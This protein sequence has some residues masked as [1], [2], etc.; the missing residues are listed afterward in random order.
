M[1]SRSELREFL[2]SRRARITPQQA[3]LP[4]YGG[5]RRVPGLRRDELANL[6]GVSVEYYTKLERGNAQGVSDSVLEALARALRLDDAERA[7]LFDLARTSSTMA[8][9]R[10]RPSRER[11]RPGIQQLLDSMTEVPAIVQN[12]RLDLLA[13]NK[14]SRALFADMLDESQ[15]GTGA[16]PNFAR[17]TFLDPRAL[18]RYPDWRHTAGD[19][20][21][22]LRAEAGR[23]PDDRQ[24]NE[25]V[26]EL[27]TRST[28]FG[29]MWASHN[30][31]WHTTGTKKLHHPVA[32]D[33][34][35]AYEGLELAADP[36]QTLIAFTAEPGSPSQQ[37]LTFLASWSASAERASDDQAAREEPAAGNA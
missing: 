27:T 20:V 21:A 24:L 32:G 7:H 23:S 9:A 4:Q 31:R 8:R 15:P 26:G 2:T 33:L 35:L 1:D 10:R 3:G 17:Y 19:I 30:V 12:G 22:L 25:L 36:D 16:A 14:L 5:R 28:E 6:A 13:S 37:A 34:V 29:A 11:V 18:E